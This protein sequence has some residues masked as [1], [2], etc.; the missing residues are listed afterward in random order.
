MILRF[1]TCTRVSSYHKPDPFSYCL[2]LSNR[3]QLRNKLRKGGPRTFVC[4][5]NSSAQQL[6]SFSETDLLE[7]IK[8]NEAGLVAVIVQ[9]PTSCQL[10]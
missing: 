3:S 4:A 10:T 1:R 7:K 8:W 9:V 2:S 5:S 6:E